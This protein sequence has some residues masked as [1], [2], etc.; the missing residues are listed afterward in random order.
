MSYL[1]NRGGV[2]DVDFGTLPLYSKEFI[3]SDTNVYSTS[4]VTAQI[5]YEATATK[6]L[7]EFEM[8]IINVICGKVT[9]GSFT[10]LVRTVDNSYLAGEF[11]IKYSIIT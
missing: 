6:E 2:V 11:K 5:L 8:D 7:D 1:P 4:S 9:D 10:I 3:I